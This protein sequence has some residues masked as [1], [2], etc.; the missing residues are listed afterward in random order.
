VKLTPIADLGGSYQD[1]YVSTDGSADI[2]TC[3][4][5]AIQRL[6]NEFRIK[7]SSKPIGAHWI[8]TVED[9]DADGRQEILTSNGR[10][11]FILSAA[12]GGILWSYDVGPPYSYG[13]Y[14]TMFQCEHMIPG[15]RG[16]QFIVPCFSHKEVLLFDCSD[17][18]ERTKLLHPLWMNDAYHPTSVIGDV[19]GDGVPEVVIARLGGVY[20]F[21]PATGKMLS[22][23][24]WNSDEQRRRN[25]GHFELADTDCTG[26]L[27]AVILSDRVTRHVALL[28][29]DG[30]G[31]FVPRWDRFIEHI[32][33]DDRTELRY[34][35][36]SVS[37]LTS[38]AIA[39]G[40]F[41]TT[42]TDRWCTEIVDP[43]T[44][45][46]IEIIEDQWLAGVTGDRLLLQYAPSRVLGE[47]S[48]VSIS[49][50][51]DNVFA[52]AEQAHFA[53][54]ALHYRGTKGQFKPEVFGQ[55]DVWSVRGKPLII[56]KSEGAYQLRT[57]SDSGASDWFIESDEPFRVAAVIDDEPIITTQSGELV[58]LDGKSI[59][60]GYHLT[61]EAHLSARPGVQATSIEDA[62]ITPRYDN[63]IQYGSQIIQG[64]GRIGYD[65]VYHNIPVFDTKSG[66]CFAVVYDEG[67]GHAR[68]KLYDLVLRQT[69]TIDLP[70]LPAS[71]HGFRIGV[72]DWQFFEHAMGDALYLA[73][74]RSP[75]MNSETSLAVL[76]DS[77]D[78]LW[79]TSSF[80]SG[81]FG[82]GIGPWGSST[83]TVID[84]KQCV[85]FCAKDTLVV[86]DLENGSFIR[87]PL[88]L[89]DLT[90]AEMQKQGTFKPQGF[91]TWSTI[92]DPFTA[93]GSVIAR[94]I[95]NDG[96]DEYII[97]GCFGGFGILDHN[98]TTLWWKISHFGDV[99][100]RIPAIV[101]LDGDGR[102]ELYQSHSDSSIRAY[103]LLD[104]EMLGRIE[105]EGIATD[106]ALH[107]QEL[108]ATTNFGKVYSLNWNDGLLQVKDSA[109]S[110]AA[111]G[112]PVV[113]RDGRIL[114]ASA[115]G[116]LFSL[117]H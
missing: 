41:N 25:Y 43:K 23:T 60:L 1:V 39:F 85:I 27:N 101:D 14:A 49:D 105:L 48:D 81:E 53:K 29:N 31:N 46:A 40:T 87:E 92:E 54:R 7:W 65:N 44:G 104:G 13:T 115:E 95:N 56:I 61:T 110:S 82:R 72:Y 62:T 11:V 2:F 102:P 19:N 116:I 35:Y 74:Y 16:K 32:Y 100:Y 8:A 63:T 88:L 37:G 55:D 113:T 73:A 10:S 96:F 26:I 28:E 68:V 98:F 71:K 80:G 15:A 52:D 58:K 21:D 69:H 109:E 93:Y 47:F 45:K 83:L 76:I 38:K 97:A 6:D 99:L 33:P 64:R 66:K 59:K 106:L 114:I 103:D 79:E 89:T 20:V 17:G 78:I 90:K 36:G 108:I 12:D 77:G 5:G 3:S 51:S 4:G 84:G 75:S 24:Q 22:S 86:L 57:F 91:D 117:S 94:D 30:K 111:L 107:G 34:C 42:L 112:S 70:H 9:L 50:S 67:V 18:A